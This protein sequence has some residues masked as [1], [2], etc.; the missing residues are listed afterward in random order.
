MSVTETK[1]SG[2]A[3]ALPRLVARV[4]GRK[5]RRAEFSRWEAYGLGLLVFGMSFIFA[6]RLIVDVVRPG[7]LEAIVLLFLPFVI[8]VAWL[9]LYFLN[10]FPIALCRS[11]GLYRAPTNNP[12]QHVIIMS[13]VTLL[14]LLLL[15]DECDWVKSL[16][17]FW[18]GLLVCNLVALAILKLWH[19]S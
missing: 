2:Y 10:S 14:S 4:A 11:L 3:F 8:W 1:E 5:V 12:F 17:A 6:A 9:L 16:G 18:L 13:L 19:E 7:W 15:R